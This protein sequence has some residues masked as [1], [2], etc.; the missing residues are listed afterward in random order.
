MRLFVI[1]TRVGLPALTLGLFLV[2]IK[3]GNGFSSGR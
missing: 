2:G 3:H 1:A